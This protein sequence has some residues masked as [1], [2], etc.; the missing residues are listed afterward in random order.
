MAALQ[1]KG[2]DAQL[3]NPQ[4]S[5][6]HAKVLVIDDGQPGGKALVS[7][8]NFAPGYFGP[9]TSNPDEG[10]TRGWRCW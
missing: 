9:E 10:G 3:S 7:D 1:A 8:F 2:L 5:Y 6:Y 4:F